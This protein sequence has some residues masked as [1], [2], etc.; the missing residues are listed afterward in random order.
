MADRFNE[1]WALYPKKKDKGHAEKAWRRLSI[2]HHDAIL[3]TL[4]EYQFPEQKFIPY[5]ATWLNGKHWLDEVSEKPKQKQSLGYQEWKPSEK[6][7]EFR[8]KAGL[9]EVK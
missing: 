7:I 9:P 5:P 2:K 3:K 4:P 8:K 1:F 6:D